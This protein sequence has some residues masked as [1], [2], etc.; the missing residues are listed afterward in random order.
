MISKQSA[1]RRL[2]WLAILI[3]FCLVAA[4]AVNPVTG[5]QE[6]VL[7]SEQQEIAMG[8]QYYPKTTQMNNGLV[9]HDQALQ[10]YV[11]QVGH[12]LA[13]N[14]HRPNIPWEFNV[15]NSDQ[16][17]AFAL[18]GGK[19]S[20]TRGLL[21]K[22]SSE[23]EMASVLAHEIGH[24][25]ARHSVAQYTRG[26]FVSMAVA[27]AGLA[28]SNTEYAQAGS[29][30]A[31]VAGSLLMLSY[32]RDQERQADDLGYEYMVRAGYNP[33]G[34]IKTF[35]MFKELNKSEP[36]FI[37]AMLSSH[38]LTSDRVQAARQRVMAAPPS[39]RNRPLQTGRFHR[40]LARQKKRQP[41]Y[42]AEAKGD[43]YMQNKNYRAAANQYKKASKLYGGDGVFLTKLA[44]AE[45]RQKDLL[46]A[47]RE[48][49]RGAKVSPGIYFPNFVAGAI[50]YQM[51]DYG[52][53]QKYLSKA[54][55][56]LPSQP[57]NKLLLAASFERLGR[58]QTAARYY[59]QVINMAPRSQEAGTAAYRLNQMG[60]RY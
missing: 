53:A 46:Q 13:R 49:S 45:Y 34:Q 27:G 37:A 52:K 24:V 17:N 9:P 33:A 44:I 4:C 3:S 39:V 41:A 20:L 50:H 29:M 32:S 55:R 15:V 60:Y 8:A 16:V 19:I 12:K 26:A 47:K 48:S 57:Q 40:E 30:A 5:Q 1:L 59:R 43:A 25:T 7:M 31:G 10:S 56:L 58:R 35:E 51:K 28:L 2:A 42:D 22:M 38:P 11:S 14:S 21:S 54:D 6:I 18:P 36:N 23:D